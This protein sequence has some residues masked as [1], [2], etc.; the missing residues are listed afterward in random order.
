MQNLKLLQLLQLADS[1]LPIGALAHSFGLESLIAEEGL[2]VTH[3]RTFLENYFAETG[4]LESFFCREAWNLAQNGATVADFP[5]QWRKLNQTLSAYKPARESRA[6]S[7]TLGKHFLQLVNRLE[8]QPL[9]RSALEANAD[10]HHSTSFGLV[11]GILEVEPEVA[12]A[13]FLQQTATALIS[14]CQRLL[15]Y[16]QTGAMQLLWQLKPSLLAVAE[17]SR[18]LAGSDPAELFCFT[19]LVELGSMRH[20]R[21]QPRLFI[22]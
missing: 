9:V 10:L 11:A 18:N 8:N 6:A 19:P 2:E 7:L 20:P 15:P 17:R 13:A 4:L 3:L 22:S 16:G 21:L 1:A 14:V 5:S 12:V